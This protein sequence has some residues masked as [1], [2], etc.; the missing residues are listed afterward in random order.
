MGQ[1]AEVKPVCWICRR[2]CQTV[3]DI[4]TIKPEYRATYEPLFRLPI[5]VD[6]SVTPRTKF[7]VE[8]ISVG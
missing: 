2:T 5:P 7:T 6:M 1:K 4:E 3:I 8:V